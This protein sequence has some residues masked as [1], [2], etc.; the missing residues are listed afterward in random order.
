MMCA[1]GAQ[2]KLNDKQESESEKLLNL[3][4]ISFLYLIT[5]SAQWQTTANVSV[6]HVSF[7]IGL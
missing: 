6:W 4:E 1:V 2:I 5:S 3:G 7:E